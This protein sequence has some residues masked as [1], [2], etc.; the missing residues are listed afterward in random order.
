MPS[1]DQPC[2]DTLARL[3]LNGLQREDPNHLMHLLNGAEDVRRPRE[4]HPA[5]IGCYDWHSSVHSHWLLVRLLR[6]WPAIE[7]A[8]RARRMLGENLRAEH[9][10]VEAAYFKAPNR[11]SFERPYGW[12]WLLKLAAELHG[13]DDP[14]ARVFRANLEPLTC[15]IVERYLGFL[16]KQRYPVRVGTH[17]STAFSM[18]LAWDYAEASGDARLLACLEEAALRYYREDA[19]APAHLEPSGDDFLSGTLTEAALMARVL[20]PTAFEAWFARFLPDLE[21]LPR[22]FCPVTVDDRSDPKL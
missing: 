12:G 17:Y 22:L 11:Q 5:F 9:I 1:L 15:V 19:D 10:Q 2:A 7:Q 14:D 20:A 18:A 21:R 4:L 16:P 6:V 13:W 8:Q 3:A